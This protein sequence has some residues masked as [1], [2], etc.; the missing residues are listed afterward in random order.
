M[1]RK[2]VYNITL[3]LAA[4]EFIS[5][6]SI[7]T[8][9]SCVCTTVPCPVNGYNYLTS[10]GGAIGKYYYSTHNGQPVVTSA[11]ITITSA[12]LDTGTDTTSCTQ[13][14]ARMLDDDGVQNCDAGHILANRLGGLGN[15][16]IN[17]FPQD[18]SI[19]RGTWAQFEDNIYDCIQEGA[20][21]AEL[22]W[23]FIYESTSHTKPYQVTYS[24]SYIGS[25]CS[26]ISTT[27]NN[28]V[29]TSSSKVKDET[30]IYVFA[31]SWTPGFCYTT[32]PSYPGCVDPNPYWTENFTVHGLWPQY[33]TTG[34]PSY[35]S[36]EN[37]DQDVPIEIGWDTMITYYPDVKYAESDPDYDS[38]W[39]HEWDKHGTCS[40]LSQYDYFQQA[41]LLA[42]TFVTPEV[43]HKYINTTDSLSTSD[44]RNAFGGS[45]YTALQCTNTNI[46]T[47]VYT[48]WS[49]SPVLQI[50][51]PESVQS[52]DTC[53]G[54]YLTIYL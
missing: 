9:S 31:Y 5:V 14:Y 20:T 42:E 27:F 36:A 10:G 52:E 24:V 34:Y 15:Q 21:S 41:I 44:L 7:V 54:E 26:S 13:D 46:L 22:S 47:G 45:T 16:P 11:Y 1:F 19:N 18:S 40:Q 51:C 4:I 49:H 37:F 38:F 3:F 30:T 53:S 39:E 33:T 17:I 6:N 8:S 28:Y 48:C 50:E 2:L 43:L 32:N 23:K 25:S 12:S 29:T 35:C